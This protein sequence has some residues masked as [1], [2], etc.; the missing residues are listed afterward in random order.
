[1]TRVE[2]VRGPIDVDRLGTTLAHEHVFVLSE[3]FRQH[4]AAWD[5]E[6]HVS[7]AIAALRA[8]H[9]RGVDTIVDPTVFGLG[10]SIPRVQRVAA[11]V[12]L[13]ILNDNGVAVHGGA[14]FG[15]RDSA[16]CFFSTLLD[17]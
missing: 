6:A 7:A 3:E 9:G 11:E 13:Q 5:E 4:D 10:R 15:L 17:E 8:L 1:V 12:E 16:R 14:R 2:T